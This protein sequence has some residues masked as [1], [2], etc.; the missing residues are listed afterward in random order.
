MTSPEVFHKMPYYPRYQANAL[1]GM[2][3]LNLE[4]RGAYNLILD[5]IYEEAGPIA[6]DDIWLARQA[7]TTTQRWK[8]IKREL[9]EAKKITIAGGMIS[10]GRAIVELGKMERRWEEYSEQ[11]KKGAAA[12]HFASDLASDSG[13]DFE[14]DL[15]S[16]NEK[17]SENQAPLFAKPYPD[18]EPKKE[19][20]SPAAPC[21][22]RAP[23]LATQGQQQRAPS[24]RVERKKR[25]PSPQ[26]L[27]DLGLLNG[28]MA[29]A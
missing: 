13:S 3:K 7:N 29:I 18:P 9:V 28:A 8:R 14:S 22:G 24:R 5:L 17:V 23:L 6:D 10:N 27:A 16:Q 4:Q 25:L 26:A 12:R 15:P 2:A 20:S 1:R 19:E 11:G 21:L